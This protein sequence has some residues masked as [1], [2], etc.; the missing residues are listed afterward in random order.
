M[1]WRI[2]SAT[3]SAFATVNMYGRT[4]NICSY[5]S[6]VNKI[7]M[8]HVARKPKVKSSRGESR[9]REREREKLPGERCNVVVIIV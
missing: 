2:F 1:K 4:T 9:E 8:L 6:E 7:M 3:S 5:A